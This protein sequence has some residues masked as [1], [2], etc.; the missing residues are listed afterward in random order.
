MIQQLFFNFTLN[1]LSNQRE[2]LLP[3]CNR[4]YKR[5]KQKKEKERKKNNLLLDAS[6]IPKFHWQG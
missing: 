6:Q 2:F 5:N 3:P 1:F 4:Q